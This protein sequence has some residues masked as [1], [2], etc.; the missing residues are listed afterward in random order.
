MVL[1]VGVYVWDEEEVP[2]HGKPRATFEPRSPEKSEAAQ[3]VGIIHLW[4][5]MPRW[6]PEPWGARSLSL[7]PAKRPHGPVLASQCSGS[8]LSPTPCLPSEA[9]THPHEPLG[10]HSLSLSSCEKA[11]SWRWG[12]KRGPTFG[13]ATTCGWQDPGA[14]SHLDG[15][16]EPWSEIVVRG[17]HA[18][19]TFHRALVATSFP[20][21]GASD[22]VPEKRYSQDPECT[23]QT[24]PQFRGMETVPLVGGLSCNLSVLSL[25]LSLWSIHL[26]SQDPAKEKHWVQRKGNNLQGQEGHAGDTGDIGPTIDRPICGK[27]P[28]P[29]RSLPHSPATLSLTSSTWGRESTQILVPWIL[30]SATSLF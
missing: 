22:E 13:L 25:S 1:G 28:W 29:H 15:T 30:A 19:W 16:W 10:T 17:E 11:S 4:L 5:Q 6:S 8:V 18:A 7:Q 3:P 26:P 9:D 14:D 20:D 21:N 23:G 27:A 12:R 24:H 2:R